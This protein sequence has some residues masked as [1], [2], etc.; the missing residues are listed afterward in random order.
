MSRFPSNPPGRYRSGWR[1]ACPVY[2]QGRLTTA[3]APLSLSLCLSRKLTCE[4]VTHSIFRCERRDAGSSVSGRS[5]CQPVP[6]DG[7][8]I[9]LTDREKSVCQHHALRL[10][11]SLNRRHSHAERREEVLDE[12]MLQ[13]RSE[14][15]I[16]QVSDGGRRRFNSGCRDGNKIQQ[17]DIYCHLVE[18]FCRFN[19]ICLASVDTSGVN[20][21]SLFICV[22]R[23][24]CF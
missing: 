1:L 20:A 2:R 19:L 13:P 15:Q 12:N 18:E 21:T 14:Q 23:K 4:P 6:S 9:T 16:S 22:Q 8:C 5:P 10:I 24:Q 7:S 11:P 17:T 3:A